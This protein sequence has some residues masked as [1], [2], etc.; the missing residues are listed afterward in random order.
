MDKNKVGI[1]SVLAGIALV[2][3][4]ANS[5]EH[6]K[7]IFYI[8]LMLIVFG[9][10]PAF[11]F[12]T[13]LATKQAVYK[14]NRL[15][16]GVILFVSGVVILALSWNFPAFQRLLTLVGFSLI[17]YG[18]RPTYTVLSK[19]LKVKNEGF[20]KP[21]TNTQKLV[22]SVSSIIVGMIVMKMIC[23]YPPPVTLLG[24]PLLFIIIYGLFTTP[25]Y[26]SR[27]LFKNVLDRPAGYFF[28]LI[29]ITAGTVGQ[30]V[31]FFKSEKELL[32]KNGKM[33]TAIVRKYASRK[34]YEIEINGKVYKSSF[35]ETDS[36]NAGDQILIKYFPENPYHNEIIS[37]IK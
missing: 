18:I 22:I 1:L 6:Q 16:I 11:L 31:Y 32:N 13:S 27:A 24:I 3:F 35:F 26:L 17:I 15:K 7:V 2:I 29:L 8:G 5:I 30:F 20:G 33:T 10:K 37:R 19:Y 9:A 23:Y 12:V 34:Y 28:I 25:L 14:E 36:L 21:R 4:Y